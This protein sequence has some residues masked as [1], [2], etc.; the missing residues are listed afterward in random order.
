M[1]KV[2]GDWEPAGGWAGIDEKSPA[3]FRYAKQLRE[4]L[5]TNQVAG[6]AVHEGTLQQLL[7]ETN[8]RA[9]AEAE[10]EALASGIADLRA[11]LEAELKHCRL[12][13]KEANRLRKELAEFK[14]WQTEIRTALGEYDNIYQMKADFART[15][16]ELAK[17]Q[18]LL[19]IERESLMR[20]LKG[21]EG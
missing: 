20:A 10:V 2:S 12:F 11:K 18:N 1:T 15:R 14:A 9:N 7:E 4:E 19:R 6:V 8:K 17:T 3:V 13:E 5:E 16:D 21:A